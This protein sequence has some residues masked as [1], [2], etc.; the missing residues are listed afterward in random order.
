VGLDVGDFG[1]EQGT[2]IAGHGRIRAA[3]K[4]GLADVPVMV[5]RG[6]T[7]AQSRLMHSPITKLALNAGWD[8]ALLSVELAELQETGFDIDLIGFD[9]SEIAALNAS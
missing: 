5:A 6:W 2:I 4:L 3:R 9:T 7:K 1:T 8:D